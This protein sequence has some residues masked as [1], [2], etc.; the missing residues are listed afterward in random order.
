MSAMKRASLKKLEY[1]AAV[2]LG[3][4]TIKVC[5]ADRHAD[6]SLHLLG[7]GECESSGI[8]EGMITDIEKASAALKQAVKQA[9]YM[10]G[11]EIT[12]VLPAISGEHIR[13]EI[14]E[15]SAVIS[16][17]T[18]SVSDIAK[19]R[20]MAG[21]AIANSE[22][23]L[24]ATLDRD[25]EIDGQAG[26]RQPLEMAGR[27][28][29]GKMHLIAANIRALENF[30]KCIN[31]AGIELV[32]Q[33]VFSGL[34]AAGA[35]LS[36]DEMKLGVCLV[37]IGAET[38]ELTIYANGNVFETKVLPYASGDI[39]HDVAHVHRASLKD[40]KRVKHELGI[41][42]AQG[43]AQEHIVLSDV[44]DGNE[45]KIAT[46]IVRDTMVCRVREIFEEVMETIHHFQE[47][48]GGKLSAGLVLVGDGALLP[49][50]RSFIERELQLGVR[51]AKP[52]YRGEKYELVEYPR[53][54][55]AVGLLTI[56]MTAPP[57]AR[58]QGLLDFLRKK[59]Q[60]W[61]TIE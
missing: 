3:N 22:R 2:D 49:G 25:Y 46:A 20:E 30:E 1:P 33:F 40:A 15:G 17:N 41:D 16:D 45:M 11:C 44:G 57:L 52:R 5:V 26:I 48:S 38:T 54:A 27:K 32:G 60:H 7:V 37:D 59:I 53:F 42:E 9:E 23:R 4:N 21:T 56:A 12:Q 47:S 24:L 43:Q 14:G 6:G 50:L 10:S 61:F 13:G 8:R 18:V 28:L 31:N 58:E 29:S 35:V 55:V 51:I 39:H 34:A 36:E 19:V